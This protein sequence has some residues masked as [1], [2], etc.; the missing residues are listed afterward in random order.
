MILTEDN[1]FS[2]VTIKRKSR[3]DLSYDCRYT[4]PDH[5]TGI[6]YIEGVRGRSDNKSRRNFTKTLTCLTSFIFFTTVYLSGGQNQLRI[7]C[8]VESFITDKSCVWG[9]QIKAIVIT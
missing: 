3:N 6:G 9:Q 1:M 4:T 7:I 2:P 8:A 5:R